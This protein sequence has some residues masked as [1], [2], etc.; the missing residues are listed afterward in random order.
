[1]PQFRSL[2][3][4]RLS[5][6]LLGVLA[7]SIILLGLRSLRTTDAF[8]LPLPRT[9]LY[10]ESAS[11]MIQ[12]ESPSPVSG[13]GYQSYPSLLKVGSRANFPTFATRT[14]SA[15]IHWS[16]SFPYRFFLILVIL[17]T[18]ILTARW[19]RHRDRAEAVSGGARQ[20]P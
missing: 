10:L 11:G 7:L 3:T 14:S 2:T 15:G 9:T 5:F 1:M 6:L 12:L 18:V 17:A 13:I 19:S 16:L 4:L 8:I 20:Q